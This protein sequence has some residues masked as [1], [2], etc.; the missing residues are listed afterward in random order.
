MKVWVDGELRDGAEAVVG[1]FDHGLLVGDGVFET[2][3]AYGGEAFALGRHY[4]RL[5]RSAGV[6]GIDVPDEPVVREAVSAVLEQ[7][8]ERVRI[9]LTGGDGAPGSAKGGGKPRL[10]VTATAFA[11]WP[12]TTDVVVVPWVRNERGALAGVKATSYG[13]NVVALEYARKRGGSEAIFGNT[14]GNLCEGTGSNVFVIW[15]G[16][17]I[18]PPLDSGCLAGVT[19]ELV[20]ELAEECGIEA[21]EEPLKLR[22]LGGAEEVFLT[23]TTRE[24]QPVARVD[25]KLVGTGDGEVAGVLG[26]AYQALV[27]RSIDP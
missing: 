15:E 12:A 7:G 6:L 11:G 14:A 2:M 5:C 26:S 4:A 21:F 27:R 17:L 20:L 8:G 9:T 1:A 22:D 13:E 25:G 23:S 24:V 3:L 16:R 18:T 19:R 10:I